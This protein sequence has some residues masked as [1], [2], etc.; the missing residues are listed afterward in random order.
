MGLRIIVAD[1]HQLVR[2]GCRVLLERE[3]LE[4]VGEASDGREAVDLVRALAPDV[5]VLDISMPELNGLD[6]AR[7]IL[8]ARP[9]TAIVILTMHVQEDHV[10]AAA[11]AGVRGYVAKTRAASELVAAIRQVAAGSTYFNTGLHSTA[12]TSLPDVDSRLR[13]TPRERL[14]L[15]LVA[16]GKATIELAAA[17]GVTTKTVETYRGRLM[18]KLGVKNTASLVRYAVRCGV[19]KAAYTIWAVHKSFL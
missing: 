11:D 9:R 16:Q 15:Q 19:V 8:H 3:G 6:A 12:A 1:D 7:E 18:R 2:Q 17:L 13:M 5:V 14:V 4:I 10:L